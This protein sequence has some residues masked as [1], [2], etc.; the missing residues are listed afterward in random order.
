M[1]ATAVAR[2]EQ[3]LSPKQRALVDAIAHAADEG[4]QLTREAAGTAA[5]YGSGEVARVAA[6]R[7]LALPHVKA[8]LMTAL[9]DT[10]QANAANALAMLRH[11]GRHSTSERVKLDASLTELRIAGLDQPEQAHQG[12]A[13]AVQIVFRTDAGTILTQAQHMPAQTQVISH[14][15]EVEHSLAEGGAEP[16]QAEGAGGGQPG[17]AP[18][19]G[20]RS[21]TET[22]GSPP[23][24]PPVA[25]PKKSR[26]K[27]KLP[28]K[29]RAVKAEKVAPVVAPAEVK[30]VRVLNLSAEERARRSEAAR[31]RNAKRWV[32]TDG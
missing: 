28:P 25:P 18:K 16:S 21:K 4:I 6:S 17:P 29:K 9:R 1:S 12:A 27:K 15:A 24:H 22:R 23:G 7:A 13:V 30:K 31:A 14:I 5:G 32:K 3:A 20:G 2:T 8:A 26:S 10:A 19:R 11:L